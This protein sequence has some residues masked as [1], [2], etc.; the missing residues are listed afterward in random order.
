MK[1]KV[2][3]TT[4]DA[5]VNNAIQK[6][7]KAI[8]PAMLSLIKEEGFATGVYNDHKGNKTA[9]VGQT[10]DYLDMPFPQVYA[11]KQKELRSMISDIDMLPSYL[12]E[13]LMSSHYRGTLRGSPAAL[14]LIKE[15]SYADAATE[16]LDNDEYREAVEK[17]LGTAGRFE[18]E[19]AA[20][21]KA[22][23]ELQ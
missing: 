19:A 8:T 18:R 10:G 4:G 22:G 6:Y 17:R 9:G 20:I 11:E 14:K 7:G 5:A 23:E 16:Y 12:Q 15:G 3:I 2:N 1:P 21:R 13:A